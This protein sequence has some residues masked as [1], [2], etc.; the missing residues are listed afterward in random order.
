MVTMTSLAA[1]CSLLAGWSYVKC[2]GIRAVHTYQDWVVSA[3][4]YSLDGGGEQDGSE[5]IVV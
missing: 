5:G 4:D 2:G 1:P 3:V